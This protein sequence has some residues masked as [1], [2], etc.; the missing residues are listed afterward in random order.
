MGVSA[1]RSVP[2]RGWW[3]GSCLLG[4]SPAAGLIV[5]RVWVCARYALRSLGDEVCLLGVPPLVSSPPP[6][7]CNSRAGTAQGSA[8]LRDPLPPGAPCRGRRP[9]DSRGGPGASASGLHTGPGEIAEERD[10]IPEAQGAPW[11]YLGQP[12]EPASLAACRPRARRPRDLE[13]L[14]IVLGET[15]GQRKHVYVLSG[16]K[17]K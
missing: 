15:S 3:E 1:W 4:Q 13:A 12:N 7:R 10:I 2:L 14:S 9:G 5:S 17:R 11:F 8:S 16:I 6:T